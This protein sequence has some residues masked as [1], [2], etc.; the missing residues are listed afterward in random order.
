MFVNVGIRVRQIDLSSV[1]VDISK[2]VKNM[3][4]LISRETLRLEVSTIDSLVRYV[5]G[6][7]PM[8]IK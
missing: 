1:R 2:G 4:E 8:H 3:S 6:L 7:G 5:S